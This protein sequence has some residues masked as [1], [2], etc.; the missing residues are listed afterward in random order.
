MKKISPAEA[1]S[2]LQ[3][4][5]CV[6]VDT[7]SIS[8]VYVGLPVSID[9]VGVRTVPFLCQDE[10]T[11]ATVRNESFVDH[12]IQNGVAGAPS[13]PSRQDPSPTPWASSDLTLC[14]VRTN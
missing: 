4:N 12:V 13:A 1:H 10:N 6:L 9:Y 3:V 7:R 14:C 2:L 11:G 8:G 5:A